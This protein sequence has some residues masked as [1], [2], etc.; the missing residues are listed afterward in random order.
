MVNSKIMPRPTEAIEHC[1]V[2]ML[3]GMTHISDTLK[4]PASGTTKYSQISQHTIS[5]S[6]YTICLG[7]RAGQVD[8]HSLT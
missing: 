3:V 1:M 7:S 8:K 5:L 6:L 2:L 4:L